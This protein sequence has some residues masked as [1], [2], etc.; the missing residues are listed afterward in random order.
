[1][2]IQDYRKQIQGGARQNS[3]QRGPKAERARLGPETTT[4]GS[5]GLWGTYRRHIDIRS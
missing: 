3:D 1:M 5:L 4:S 2:P